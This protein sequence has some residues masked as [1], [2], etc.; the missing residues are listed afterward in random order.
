MGVKVR[1]KVIPSSFLKNEGRR[2]DARWGKRAG[3]KEQIQELKGA[4]DPSQEQ[5]R[6]REEGA[7]EMSGEERLPKKRWRRVGMSR[8]LRGRRSEE[9]I[10]LSTSSPQGSE[11]PVESQ[12]G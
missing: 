11:V 4:S 2:R 12:R 3:R 7:K 10:Q 8:S 9:M 6:A 1:S 5:E